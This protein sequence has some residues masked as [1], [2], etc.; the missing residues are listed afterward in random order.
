MAD[1]ISLLTELEHSGQ[2][3]SYKYLAPTE[4]IHS[5]T[6]EESEDNS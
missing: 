4:L 5:L 3:V 6:N 1:H 2:I